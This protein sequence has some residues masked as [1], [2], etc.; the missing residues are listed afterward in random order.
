MKNF[1]L[2][3][4]FVTCAALLGAILGIGPYLEPNSS[5]AASAT[6][7]EPVTVKSI[8]AHRK[9]F[10]KD[11]KTDKRVCLAQADVAKIILLALIEKEQ[12]ALR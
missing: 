11:L 8:I 5:V 10:C 7:Y 9:P 2:A 1:K 6:T 3:L 12:M 4:L